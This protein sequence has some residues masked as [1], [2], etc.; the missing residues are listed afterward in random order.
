MGPPRKSSKS[1]RKKQ[2]FDGAETKQRFDG[3]ETRDES[4]TTTDSNL[5]DHVMVD[6]SEIHYQESPNAI[7]P[8]TEQCKHLTH[9]SEVGWDVQK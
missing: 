4:H 7:F 1:R 5:K 8:L 3:T 9:V 6:A 2:K